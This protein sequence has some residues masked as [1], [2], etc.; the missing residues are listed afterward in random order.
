MTKVEAV[1]FQTCPHSGC[2]MPIPEYYSNHERSAIGADTVQEFACRGCSKRMYLYK[3]RRGWRTAI[4]RPYQDMEQT[5]G[6]ARFP[7]YV[8]SVKQALYI[9]LTP[10]TTRWAGPPA[11]CRCPNSAGGQACDKLL[12]KMIWSEPHTPGRGFL[13]GIV[14][15]DKRLR[16]RIEDSPHVHERLREALLGVALFVCPRC[17]TETAFVFRDG[18]LSR[19][20]PIETLFQTVA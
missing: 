17:R 16:G 18:R 19:R 12:A 9:D 20:V 5:P 10:K 13:A 7:I 11:H 8:V 4:E 2:G 6:L 14:V 15:S 1:G 3:T